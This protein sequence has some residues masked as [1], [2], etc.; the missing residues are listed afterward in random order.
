M[1]AFDYFKLE[2]DQEKKSLNL[3]QC[4]S[5]GDGNHIDEGQFFYILTS[6]LEGDA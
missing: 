2:D 3:S 1:Q 5:D 4:W 6:V